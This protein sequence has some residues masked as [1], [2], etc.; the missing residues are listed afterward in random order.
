[1]ALLRGLVTPSKIIGK[2]SVL[3]MTVLAVKGYCI[4]ILEI[5]PTLIRYRWSYACIFHALF[6]PTIFNYY[7]VAFMSSTHSSTSDDEVIF[8]DEWVPCTRDG[9][10]RRCHRDACTG[11]VKQPRSRH[12]GECKRDRHAFD[13]HCPWFDACIAHDTIPSFILTCILMPAVSTFGALPILPSLYSGFHH[14]RHFS[15]V[16]EWISAN[17]WNTRL[18]YPP[19]PLGARAIRYALGY[20][21]LSNVEGI[22]PSVYHVRWDVTFSALSA[23]LVSIVASALLYTV[24]SGVLTARS[25]VDLERCKSYT[26]VTRKLDKDPSNTH[27]IATAAALEPVEHFRST[28]TNSIIKT[29]ITVWHLGWY[30]NC[31]R[32]LFNEY[33]HTL[34]EEYTRKRE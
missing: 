8:N 18:A 1:M 34:N 6:I 4:C 7:R 15:K 28:R 3:L 13:H 9:S 32:L 5:A 14:A 16:D 2:C 11:R 10:Q 33:Q 21:R 30:R 24:A 22:R 19:G 27:L 17:F 23:F 25:S 29:D 26:K 12:C 31:R 20:W